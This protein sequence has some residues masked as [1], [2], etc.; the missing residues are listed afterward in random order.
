MS[1]IESHLELVSGQLVAVLLKGTNDTQL[2]EVLS[3]DAE[4]VCG[5]T[6]LGTQVEIDAC[7]IESIAPQGMA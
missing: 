6:N 3:V 5:L 2:L 7:D 4:R 1:N